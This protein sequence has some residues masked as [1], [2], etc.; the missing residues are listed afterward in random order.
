[1]PI[2]YC[3][4]HGCHNEM[5]Y[6]GDYKF[7][8][9][10]VRSNYSFVLERNE[11]VL[12]LDLR[13]LYEVNIFKWWGHE[14]QSVVQVT[15]R[16]AWKWIIMLMFKLESL[17]RNFTFPSLFSALSYMERLFCEVVFLFHFWKT[18]LAINKSHFFDGYSRWIARWSHWKPAK[19]PRRHGKY[20]LDKN[21]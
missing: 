9:M 16:N 5:T 15:K 1:M 10:H 20:F 18:S 6:S 13:Q 21:S 3:W 8:L 12:L 7:Y 17:V 4:S 11:S 2:I 14:C 19:F